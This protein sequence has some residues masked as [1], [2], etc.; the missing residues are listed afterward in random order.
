[1]ALMLVLAPRGRDVRVP[2]LGHPPARELNRALVERWFEL[3]QEEGL[4]NVEDARHDLQKL[5]ARPSWSGTDRTRGHRRA[6]PGPRARASESTRTGITSDCNNLVS[7][8]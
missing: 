2:A 7:I 6:A 3:Q 8:T 5:A 4:L 1:M